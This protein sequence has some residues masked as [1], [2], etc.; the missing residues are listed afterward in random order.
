MATIKN[1]L[2]AKLQYDLKRL[3]I[4]TSKF[5]FKTALV[6]QAL[7]ALDREHISENTINKLKDRLT[8]KEKEKML[9]EARIATSWIY[10]YIKKI[11]LN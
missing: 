10:E 2:M 7:K 11:C 6:I 8:K 4:K 1:I 3:Q 5:F 9:K